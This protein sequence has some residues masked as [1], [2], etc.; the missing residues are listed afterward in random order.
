[1]KSLFCFIT[2]PSENETKKKKK[3]P[4]WRW[5]GFGLNKSSR[6]VNTKVNR[7]NLKNYIGQCP[8]SRD[9]DILRT[10]PSA[11]RVHLGSHWTCV[12]ELFIVI[13]KSYGLE[14]SIKSINKCV[15]SG[16]GRRKA[17]SVNLQGCSTQIPWKKYVCFHN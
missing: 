3:G 4:E 6:F 5:F 14:V 17:I 9:K 12:I 2:L 16:R 15:C 11:R 8:S 7:L 13:A 1:M 10:I